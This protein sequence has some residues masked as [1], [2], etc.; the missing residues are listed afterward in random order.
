MPTPTPTPTRPDREPTVFEGEAQIKR[1]LVAFLAFEVG[2]GDPK[3]EAVVRESASPSFARQLLSEPAAIP[4]RP[5]PGLARI[6]SLHIYPVP[7]H[8]DLVLASGDAR[9]RGGPEPFSFLFE[10]RSGR[11]LALAPGE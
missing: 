6:T 1:F 8:R 4:R 2:D 7:G 3:T 9:R 11:W 10:R 5:N